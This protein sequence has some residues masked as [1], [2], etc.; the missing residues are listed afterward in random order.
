MVH[1]CCGRGSTWSPSHLIIPILRGALRLRTEHQHGSWD[2]YHY[3]HWHHRNPVYLHHVCASDIS[4]VAIPELILGTNLV[5]G[6]EIEIVWPKI[7][8]RGWRIDVG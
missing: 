8:R 5:Y 7:Q 3:S 2:Q 4:A 6:P 1:A